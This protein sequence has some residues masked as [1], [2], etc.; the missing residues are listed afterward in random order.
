MYDIEQLNDL[1]IPELIDIAEEL[2]IPNPKKLNKQD[3]VSSI[4]DK[5]SNMATE[6]NPDSDKPKRKRI[7]KPEPAKPAELFKRRPE[8][9][10]AEREA[11]RKEEE[12]AEDEAEEE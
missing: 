11:L 1:L 10:V 3:L 9:V 2:E 4:L 5:Q 7:P 6:K 12:A 8:V